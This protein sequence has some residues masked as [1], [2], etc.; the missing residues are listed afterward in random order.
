[1]SVKDF[2]SNKNNWV[3]YYPE[4]AYFLPEFEKLTSKDEENQF[5]QEQKRKMTI[6]CLY[7]DIVII[8]PEHFI[9]TSTS[10]KIYND[11]NL[12]TLFDKGIIATTYWE[13]LSD[14]KAFVEALKDYLESIGQGYVFKKPQTKELES[15]KH[16]LRDVTGQS[17]WL[18]ETLLNFINDNEEKIVNRYSPKIF[19]GF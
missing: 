7:F 9:R 18:I 17:Q 19:G 5:L 2:S 11:P 6:L 12:R 15:I 1:M 4:L 13:H 3:V 14:A 8:P 10:T 16:F